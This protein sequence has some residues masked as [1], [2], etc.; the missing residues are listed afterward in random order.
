VLREGVVVGLANHTVLRARGGLEVPIDDSGA[1]IRSEDGRLV[2][3]VLVF[4]DVTV[5]K[6]ARARSE[7]LAKAGEALASNLEYEATLGSVARLSV[8][9]LADWCAIDLLDSPGGALRQVAVAHVDPTRVQMAREYRE[10]YAPDPDAAQG[11]PRVART[12]RAELY[13]EIEAHRLE[14]SARDEEQRRFIR[15]LGL[16]SAMLVPIRARG[17]ILGVITLIHA[18]SGRRYTP[19]DL[20]FAEDF[21]RRAGLAIENAMALKEAEEAR[22]RERGMRDEAELASRAKDEF[23][24]TVSHELRTPLNAIL[25]WTVIIRR[26]GLGGDLDRAVGIIERNARAQARLINDVLDLSRVISGKM[27]LNMATTRVAEI[28]ASAVETVAPAAAAKGIQIDMDVPDPSLEIVADADRLQQVIWNLLSNSVKFTPKDGHVHVSVRQ[29]GSDLSI[30]VRDTGEGI[31]DDLLPV[32]FK[33][34]QQADNSTTRRH[35]GLGL[36]LT[37]VKQLVGAHGGSVRA[38]SEGQGKGATFVIELPKRAAVPA[39]VRAPPAAP[40]TASLE[41][42]EKDLTRLDGL[43]LL[44]VDD[45]EDARTMLTE[46]LRHYGASVQAAA[47]AREALERFGVAQPDVLVSD[48]GMPETDGY[49]LIRQIRSRP[50][51]QGGG[52]P[53]VALTAYAQAEDEQRALAAGYQVHVPKPVEPSRLAAVVARLGGRGRAETVGVQ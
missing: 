27:A 46:V 40:S 20:T 1:P 9:V 52:T 44:I 41:P 4:R 39:L 31:R 53:A 28:V 34:F 5:E 19:D 21:A 25:G 30:R 37:I 22:T 18:E 11:A 7:F 35:G 47:S 32:I 10:R 42:Q 49:S 24:A 48:I 51:Q 15:E 3:V 33:P 23:L 8:P 12:G 16:G 36:G 43:R 29:T 50:P 45:E 6:R 38:E 13:P 14:S 2:G 26:R 17:R